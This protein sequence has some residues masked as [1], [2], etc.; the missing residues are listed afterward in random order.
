MTEEDLEIPHNF[1]LTEACSIIWWFSVNI[2][3]NSCKDVI[4]NYRFLDGVTIRN[5]RNGA[6]G[7]TDHSDLSVTLSFKK[8]EK[9]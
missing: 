4:E 3:F 8:V 9:Y 6:V 7:C 5:T 1:H 2:T